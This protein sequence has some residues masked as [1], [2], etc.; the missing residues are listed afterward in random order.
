MGPDCDKTYSLPAGSLQSYLLG[1]LAATPAARASM[2][3]SAVAA[4]SFHLNE[5]LECASLY[6]LRG[7]AIRCIQDAV[8]DPDTCHSDHTAMAIA[9]LGVFEIILGCDEATQ[10]HVR[11]LASIKAAR[12]GSLHWVL[13]GV[14][15]WMANLQRQQITKGTITV[16][17]RSNMET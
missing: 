10:T 3:I 15:S 14:L 7:Y 6:G 17:D 8:T 5:P 13:D 4:M 9:S 1:S 16:L 12:G 11:G 2:V